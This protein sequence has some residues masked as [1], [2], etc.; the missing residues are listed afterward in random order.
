MHRCRV[1][2]TILTHCADGQED[3]AGHDGRAIM[4][5]SDHRAPELASLSRIKAPILILAGSGDQYFPLERLDAWKEL[6]ADAGVNFS[7]YLLKTAPM[8]VSQ[9]SIPSL[10]SSIY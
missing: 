3:P 5:R 9:A 1:P 10:M 2:R 4:M 8:S 6:L 7:L